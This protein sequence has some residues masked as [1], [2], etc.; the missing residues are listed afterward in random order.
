M[1]DDDLS[2][3]LRDAQDRLRR[4]EAKTE[5]LESVTVGQAAWMTDMQQEVSARL[6]EMADLSHHVAG[7]TEWLT[8][9]ERWVSSCVKTLANF[10]AQPL[11]TQDPSS[12]GTVD[13]TGSLMARLEVATVM[14]WIASVA[15]VPEG[16]VITVT[17]A[18]R[19]RPEMLRQA[20]DSVLHQSYGRFELLVVDDSDTDETQELLATLDDPRLR[21]VRTAARRGAGSTFNLGLEEATGDIIAFLDED[22]LMHPEWLRSVAWAF[23]SFPEV[24]A[25]YGA[26]S[27]EDPGA[28]LGVRS[29]M[30]P[31]LEFSHY[32]RARHERA[33][34]VD[35]NTI[36]F[37]SFL[38]DIRY[39]ESL[40]AAF[41]WDHSLRLFARAE[42]LPLPALSCY[43]RTLIPDRVSDIPE[44]RESVLRVRSRVHE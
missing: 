17:V 40:R 21:T 28:R 24:D 29:G 1:P 16:P 2:Q 3:A 37:R 15:E 4:L 13:V 43:Y 10:G 26:R 27:N 41:D 42:P 25:L 23:S 22:N 30:L 20:L 44:Q 12:S 8:T 9:L 38:K 35:R 31:T 7:H 6:R 18:T 11:D 32:D 36:A 39:D 5:A 34:F 14:D 33:N 19:N